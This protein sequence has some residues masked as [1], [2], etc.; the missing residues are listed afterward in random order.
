MGVMQ[1]VSLAHDTFATGMPLPSDAVDSGYRSGDLE[2]WFIPSDTAALVVS[3]DMVE[4][5]PRF[6]YVGVCV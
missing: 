6:D 4:R 2:L 1:M 3:P 5:W